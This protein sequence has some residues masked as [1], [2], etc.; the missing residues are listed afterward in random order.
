MTTIPTFD[1]PMKLHS[2]PIDTILNFSYHVFQP[3]ATT[4]IDFVVIRMHGEIYNKFHL[5]VANRSS[6][7]DIQIVI[8]W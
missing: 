1:R 7:E 5:L 3:F 8:F 6:L 2:L 4:T